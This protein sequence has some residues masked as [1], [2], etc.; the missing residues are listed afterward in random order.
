[1]P[2]TVRATDQADVLYVCVN[3]LVGF[4]QA[5]Q[6]HRGGY[7]EIMLDPS[8]AVAV[9]AAIFRLG[10]AIPPFLESRR[11]S[12][13]SPP[14]QCSPLPRAAIGRLDP[15]RKHCETRK[16][17]CGCGALTAHATGISVMEGA[18]YYGVSTDKQGA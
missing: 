18:S 1:V 4:R 9:I 11:S 6:R 14:V 12:N 3:L 7:A 16:A 17:G 2:A 15:S 8:N 5:V 10:I 13:R